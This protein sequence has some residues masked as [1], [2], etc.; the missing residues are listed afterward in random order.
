MSATVFNTHG[1]TVVE[2]VSGGLRFSGEAELTETAADA[3]VE[4]LR[5]W[6]SLSAVKRHLA[7]H[8]ADAGTILRKPRY[9]ETS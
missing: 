6:K 2:T 4:A 7:R 1:L 5:R 3:L 9:V 8:A